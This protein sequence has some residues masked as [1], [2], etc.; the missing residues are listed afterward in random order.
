M[1][2]GTGHVRGGPWEPILIAG[3]VGLFTRNT[4]WRGHGSGREVGAK[5][6]MEKRHLKSLR[7]VA[8]PREV[9]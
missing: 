1:L 9:R 2:P 6:R 4:L 8:K 3:D 7:S 5:G